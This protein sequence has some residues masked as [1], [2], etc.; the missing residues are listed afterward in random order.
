MGEELLDLLAGEHGREAFGLLGAEGVDGLLDGLAEHLTIE[1]EDGLEGLILCAGGHVLLDG[2]V[3]E[4]R[5]DLGGAHLGGVALV[6]EADE[7]LVRMDG[8]LLRGGRG[9]GSNESD[10]DMTWCSRCA[11]I[12]RDLGRLSYCTRWMPQKST[13]RGIMRTPHNLPIERAKTESV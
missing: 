13:P 11:K 2:Q 3:G 5:L 10:I 7:A 9:S 4:E 12:A 1:E 8:G 6:V